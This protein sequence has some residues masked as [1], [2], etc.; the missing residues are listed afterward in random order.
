MVWP[1]RESHLV[2]VARV[3]VVVGEVQLESVAQPQAQRR[4]G[5]GLG[6]LVLE[7]G[8]GRRGA[9]RVAVL[10]RR[11]VVVL[12]AARAPLLVLVL[13]V[14]VVLVLAEVAARVVLAEAAAAAA[15][16]AAATVL[17][18]RPRLVD[19][20]CTPKSVFLLQEHSLKFF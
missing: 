4:T 18:V 2:A 20:T 13:L 12:P 3:L 14:V 1:L 6:L 15:A 17:A 7:A 9:V 8:V 19:R 10:H 11:V 16:A 5:L